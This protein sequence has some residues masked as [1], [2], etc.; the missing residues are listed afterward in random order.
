MA[1]MTVNDTTNTL[2]AKIIFGG[3]G[4]AE[5]WVEEAKRRGLPN[6]KSMVDAIPALVTDNLSRC[7]NGSMYLMKLSF[8]PVLRSNMR[9]TAKQLISKL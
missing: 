3:N 1:G 7:L 5:E 4:Y 8:I 9:H 6:L 2:T